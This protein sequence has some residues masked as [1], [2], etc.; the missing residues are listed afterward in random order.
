MRDI[1]CVPERLDT[2]KL[3]W[4]YWGMFSE[5]RLLPCLPKITE[6]NLMDKG[7]RAELQQHSINFGVRDLRQLLEET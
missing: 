2:F 1:V 3:L 7:Q 6:E 5:L 4:L